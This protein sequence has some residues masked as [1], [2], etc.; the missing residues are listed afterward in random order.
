MRNW[1]N[2]SW[3]HRPIF[4]VR[5]FLTF[6]HG[7]VDVGNNDLGVR[8]VALKLG[9]DDAGIGNDGVCVY[10]IVADVG[11]DCVRVYCKFG[12]EVNN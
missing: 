1:N 7:A 12:L 2:R 8:D 4:T 6:H 5:P 11:N 9:N 10:G 3:Y